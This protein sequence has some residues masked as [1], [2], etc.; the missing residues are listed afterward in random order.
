MQQPMLKRKAAIHL[1]TLRVQNARTGVYQRVR[2]T[3]FVNE[4]GE[5][6]ML[7]HRGPQIIYGHVES[8]SM[9]QTLACISDV[10]AAPGR[11]YLNEYRRPGKESALM[12][13]PNMIAQKI[14]GYTKSGKPGADTLANVARVLEAASID[15]MEDRLMTMTTF[16]AQHIRRLFGDKVPV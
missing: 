1:E 12:Y 14:I 13:L 9:A 4:D 10:L 15:D 8:E 11:P 5:E 2:V 3:I 16:E 6:A 7:V